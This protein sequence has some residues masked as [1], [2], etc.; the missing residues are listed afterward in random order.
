[1]TDTKTQTDEPT[2]H[3]TDFRKR[4][5]TTIDRLGG[6]ARAAKFAN[7]SDDTLANWRD[8]KSKPSFFGMRN[9]ARTAGVSLDW[10]ANG[11]SPAAGTGGDLVFIPRL[12]RENAFSVSDERDYWDFAI[13]KDWTR[14][15]LGVKPEKLAVTLADTDSMDPTIRSGDLL[16]LDL[17]ITTFTADAI[18][19]FKMRGTHILRRIQTLSDGTAILKPDNPAYRE[20][21][22]STEE[23][24][25]ISVVGVVK[26]IGRRG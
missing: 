5:S 9:L 3:A 23:V 26:W 19:L 16:L 21:N 15:V 20:E 8:G 17:G 7:V 2:F 12:E 10:L 25:G 24:R 13:R 6:L 1:M 11:E 4:L 22:L 14:A 18:Y